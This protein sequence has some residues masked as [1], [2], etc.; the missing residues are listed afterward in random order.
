M[1]AKIISFETK[2]PI[3]SFCK[4]PK[5]KVKHLIS[6]KNGYICN[7]CLEKCTKLI[8]DN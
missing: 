3:C 7:T 5:S 8:K 1:T 4:K 2:E 6:G